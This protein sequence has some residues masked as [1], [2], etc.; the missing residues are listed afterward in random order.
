MMKNLIKIVLIMSLFVVPASCEVVKP[1]IIED[2]A[3]VGTVDVTLLYDASVMNVTGVADGDFDVIIKNLE[4]VRE[5]FVRIGA[6]QT[7]NFGL[8]GQINLASITLD[9]DSA[10]FGSLT[11]TVN[12]L[13][14]ATPQCNPISYTIDGCT[15]RVSSS[16]FPA[17]SGDVGG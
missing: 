16:T 11:M 7:N 9:C 10:D 12:T 1:L 15:I 3:N 13:M 14:D 4:R 2:A 5:G 6:V 17:D 8:N